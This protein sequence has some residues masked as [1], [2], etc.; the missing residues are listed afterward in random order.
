CVAWIAPYWGEVNDV[1]DQYRDQ[2]RLCA[3]IV[4]EQLKNPEPELF[5]HMP[6]AVASYCALEADGVDP[7]N[8]LSL[9]FSKSFPFQLKQS[10]TEQ[11]FD[12]GLVELSAVIAAM[13]KIPNP[14]PLELDDD[15]M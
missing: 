3:S 4:A 5:D 8:W 1:T 12:E 2:V 6:K 13:S 11:K 14:K 7:S 15:Q 9:L 10:K